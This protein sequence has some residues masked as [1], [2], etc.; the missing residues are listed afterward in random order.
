M[1]NS[2]MKTMNVKDFISMASS[3]SDSAPLQTGAARNKAD[4][5]SNEGTDYTASNEG[6][7][8]EAIEFDK[9]S[10]QYEK[11]SKRSPRRLILFIFAFVVI[12]IASAIAGFGVLR[13]KKNSSSES[14][15]QQS[16][17]VTNNEGNAEDS[18]KIIDPEEDSVKD[19][20]NRTESS[21]LSPTSAPSS[22]LSQTATTQLS[23]RGSS[24]ASFF[25]TVE[26]LWSDNRSSESESSDMEL[27][28]DKDVSSESVSSEVQLG[29]DNISSESVSTAG[30]LLWSDPACPNHNLDVS[31]SCVIGASTSI[32]T[33]S[34]CF[35][36]KSDGDWYWIRSSGSDAYDSWDYT[37]ETEG[38]LTI[39]DLSRG[40]YII[41]LV[42]DSMH[43]YNEIISHEFTV[44]Q[45]E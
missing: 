30:D 20:V 2:Q 9:P 12:L 26:S 34:F 11:V 33:A 1:V 27:P 8:V 45:C 39:M 21:V 31:S 41:S 24:P 7:E 5:S 40:Q 38:G 10:L 13:S 35:A 44:P 6:I 18:I 32:S 3:R 15:L 43:P 14:E 22:T 16:V 42:R 28:Q 25:S 19:A 17:N 36:S 29:N 37:D 4:T 23:S